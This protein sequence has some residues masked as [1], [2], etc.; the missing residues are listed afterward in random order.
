LSGQSVANIE[1]MAARQ[2]GFIFLVMVSFSVF[3]LVG[4]SA[5]FVCKSVVGGFSFE[6]AQKEVAE[7]QR[8]GYKSM[9]V[10]DGHV[11]GGYS[12]YSDFATAELAKEY[13]QSL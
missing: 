5:N 1:N 10:K 9:A 11:V 4:G 3:Y 6:D 7:L 2:S 8:M 12:S 13:Y